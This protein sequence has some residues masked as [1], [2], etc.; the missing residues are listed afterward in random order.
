MCIQSVSYTHLAASYSIPASAWTSPVVL[1]QNGE[2]GKPGATGPAGKPG[3]DGADGIGIKS[4]SEK[5]AIS[6]SNTVEPTTWQDT[7]PTMTATNRYLWNYETITFTNNTTTTTKKRVIGVYGDKGQTGGQ[8]KPGADG[9]DG[10]GI[11][12]IT[13][14]LYTSTGRKNY[15]NNLL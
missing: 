10:K 9:A 6:N 7:P 11:K 2:N 3:A 14:L 12:S 8:G 15:S 4:I 5:Y 1:T 13:C